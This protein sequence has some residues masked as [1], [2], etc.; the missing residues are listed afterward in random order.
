VDANERD[1]TAELA[2][3]Q[4]AKLTPW[5]HGYDYVVYDNPAK[6]TTMQQ[7]R[8]EIIASIRKWTVS[9]IDNAVSSLPFEYQTYKDK[10]VEWGTHAR[11]FISELYL[12]HTAIARVSQRYFD[13]HP[14]LFSDRQEEL[15]RLIKGMEDIVDLY[16]RTLAPLLSRHS[17]DLESIKQAILPHVMVKATYF[18]DHARAETLF[19]F[20]EQNAAHCPI[21]IRGEA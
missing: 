10:I 15:D 21:R 6:A 18:V 1:G 16:N 13:G 12:T 9:K 11:S 14:V 8:N 5:F 17:I 7:K 4:V 20:G 3:V 19:Q 2:G